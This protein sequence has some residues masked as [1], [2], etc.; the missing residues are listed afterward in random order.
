MRLAIVAALLAFTAILPAQR[1]GFYGRPDGVRDVGWAFCRLQYTSVRKSVSGTGWQTDFPQADA[2]LMRRVENLTTVRIVRRNLRNTSTGQP[3]RSGPRNYT[4]RASMPTDGLEACP[5]VYTADASTLA[6]DDGEPERLRAY[7][8]KGGLLWVDDSWGTDGWVTF[9]TQMARVLDPGVHPWFDLP[10]EHAVTTAPYAVDPRDHQM[11]H[12][13]FWR[14]SGGLTSELD[15]E[16]ADVWLRGIAD[17][18]GRLMVLA[19]WNTDV[20]DGWEREADDAYFEAFAAPSYAF[21]VN[22]VIYALTH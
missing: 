13:G 9:A 16:S 21:G 10:R 12:A 2:N 17:S 5:F 22:V 14:G 19:T 6:W 7:L 3:H 15:A 18:R 4:V 8:L 11:S 1:L 20:G